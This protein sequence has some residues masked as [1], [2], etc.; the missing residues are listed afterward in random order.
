MPR[1]NGTWL[2][3]EGPMTGR[4]MGLCVLKKEGEDPNQIMGF[5]GIA[6]KPY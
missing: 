3:G 2:Q 1:G 4:G 5:I 6:G